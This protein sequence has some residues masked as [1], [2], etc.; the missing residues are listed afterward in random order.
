MFMLIFNICTNSNILTLF[1]ILKYLFTIICILLPIIMMYRILVPLFKV[2][3]SGDKLTN[4]LSGVFKSFIAALV[5]F[6]LP[7]I[8]NYAFTR[9]IPLNSIFSECYNN[10]TYDNV[11]KYRELEEI[12]RKE[13]Q[14][15]YERDVA[16]SIEKAEAEEKEKNEKLQDIRDEFIDDEVSTGSS[17]SGGNS[18]S[19]SSSSNNDSGN[20]VGSSNSPS[21]GDNMLMPATAN[22]IIGDS[23]T[24]GMCAAITGDWTYCQF[25]NGG[26]KYDGNNIYIAQGSMGYS[27]FN[28]TAV[29]AVNNIIANN[30]DT[31]F[32]IYSLMGVNFLLS[33]IN[34]YI[35]K[36][37]SLATNDWK[38]HNLILVS[39]NPVD[40]VLEAQYGYST[41]NA[42]I[43][44]FNTQLKNGT[45]GVSNIK[46]CDTYN[47]ILSNLS[48]SDGLHYTS[49]TYSAIY[50][51]M[52]TCGG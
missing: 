50:N 43:V 26:A 24:V 2:V 31:T 14:D 37:N 15:Q 20:N 1:L 28:S 34:K 12:E 51:S 40:E 16:E 27:W 22:I 41:K 39:V 44:S 48:T 25:S 10:A 8:I 5:V 49:S 45:S 38:N 29:S 46:Y 19:G 21:S 23:R 6:L 13:N 47:S 30:P 52:M 33:D 3:I 9:L 32:N 7:G 18:S 35:P 42:D 4:E 36:Y 11:V 17:Q